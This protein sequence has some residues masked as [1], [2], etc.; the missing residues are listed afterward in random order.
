M[1]RL[2]LLEGSSLSTQLPEKQN[3]SDLDTS[4]KEAILSQFAEEY[5]EFIKDGGEMD[6]LTDTYTGNLAVVVRNNFIHTFLF[7]NN[8]G[9]DGDMFFSQY[10]TF[11]AKKIQEKTK[12]AFSGVQ[13][14][15]DFGSE[16]P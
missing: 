13:L 7:Q 14:S 5:A 12:G 16:N 8:I 15:M 4:V 2:V 6:K 1:N 11:I 3:F 10:E 9:C